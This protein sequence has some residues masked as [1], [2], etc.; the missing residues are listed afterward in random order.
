MP[1]T[2]DGRE[3]VTRRGAGEIPPDVLEGAPGLASTEPNATA[4]PGR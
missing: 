1:T 4:L 3:F 2:A